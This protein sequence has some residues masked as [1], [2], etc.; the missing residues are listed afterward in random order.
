MKMDYDELPQRY[1]GGMQRYFEHGIMPGEF[2]SCV[3]RNELYETYRVADD[4]SLE[5]L[6]LV[7]TWLVTEP[8][9]QA[10]GHPTRVQNWCRARRDDREQYNPGAPSPRA[11]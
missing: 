5:A 7:M 10:W 3:L 6:S 11:T 4:K 1:R 9:A 2:L 8:P